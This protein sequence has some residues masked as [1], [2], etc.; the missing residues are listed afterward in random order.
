MWLTPEFQIKIRAVTFEQTSPKMVTHTVKNT[1]TLTHPESWAKYIATIFTREADK[2]TVG[3]LSAGLQ[4]VYLC[5]TQR[6]DA[7]CKWAETSEGNALITHSLMTPRR[8]TTGVPISGSTK[9][10]IYR[11]LLYEH[12]FLLPSTSFPGKPKKSFF[13]PHIKPA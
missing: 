7:A 3:I 2:P 9:P 5:R 13:F 6:L 12:H 4:P 1:H 10:P 11:L 8:R